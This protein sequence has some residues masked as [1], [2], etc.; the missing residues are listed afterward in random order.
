MTLVK[1]GSI[2]VNFD[3][4]ALV[5][6]VSPTPGGA[7]LVRLEFGEEHRIDVSTHAQELLDWIDQ[8]AANTTT[9]A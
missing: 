2:V 4:V 9:T 5:R 1:L 8:N 7:K 6:D 3:R